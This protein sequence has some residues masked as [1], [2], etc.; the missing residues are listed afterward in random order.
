MRFKAGGSERA[1]LEKQ[2]SNFPG[3]IYITL[4]GIEHAEPTL[5]DNA[6]ARRVNVK[7]TIKIV[8]DDLVERRKASMVFVQE[9][10]EWLIQR[11]GF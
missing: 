6:A 1:R 3:K 7:V 9:Q 11:E 10:G 5:D 4:H 8:V 2:I